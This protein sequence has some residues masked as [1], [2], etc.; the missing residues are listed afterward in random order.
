LCWIDCSFTNDYRE[1]LFITL[2]QIQEEKRKG[3]TFWSMGYHDYRER[4]LTKEQFWYEAMLYPKMLESRVTRV[5]ALKYIAEQEK[6][7][8]P[9]IRRNQQSQRGILYEYLA[10]ITD[11]DGAKSEL[12]DLGDDWFEL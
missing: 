8:A 7:I 9:F 3:I 12:E 4:Y 11:A 6:E 1:F 10:D 5:E 2:S